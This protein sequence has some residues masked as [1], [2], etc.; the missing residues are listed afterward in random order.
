MYS[1]QGAIDLKGSQD[2]IKH[3]EDALRGHSK[4]A[5]FTMANFTVNQDGVDLDELIKALASVPNLT[6]V[7]IAAHKTA[8]AHF[9]GQALAAL[10]AD[11]Q[12]QELRIA[13]FRLEPQH[14]DLIAAAV[15]KTTTLQNL[16]LNNVGMAQPCLL[17]LAHQCMKTNKTLVM[18]DL[19]S[20][21]LEDIGVAALAS[22]LHK[23]ATLKHLRLWDNKLIGDDGYQ[24]LA[25]LLTIN[26]VIE[27]MEVP[28][29][30]GN[31][32]H[33]TKIENLIKDKRMAM[34]A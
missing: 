5:S 28:P 7:N 21:N 31:C 30:T 23:H 15:A 14:Y 1:S 25:E 16:R 13:N 27:K 12:F 33:R 6:S 3:L 20:N 11:N 34:A 10:V 8:T 32:E 18:L 29:N 9:T 2:D 26:P 4:L 17:K 24:A 19:S 22:T